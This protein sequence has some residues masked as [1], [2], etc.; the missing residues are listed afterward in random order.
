MKRSILGLVLVVSLALFSPG[1][2]FSQSAD[3]ESAVQAAATAPVAY[4][5]ARTY[6]SMSADIRPSASRHRANSY[7]DSCGRR[8]GEG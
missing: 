2:G 1:P 3:N 7:P 4:L 6:D 5:Y 8:S